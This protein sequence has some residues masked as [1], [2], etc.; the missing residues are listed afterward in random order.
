MP[1]AE[2]DVTLLLEEA[3]LGDAGAADRLTR[4]VYDTMHRIAVSALRQ[5]R[6]G[7]TMQP[8]ELVDEAFVPG[9]P[10][11]RHLRH[12]PAASVP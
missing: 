10:P 5:E 9:T 4:A 1:P 6:D 7:H 8:T 3:R 11:P 12:T 2:P